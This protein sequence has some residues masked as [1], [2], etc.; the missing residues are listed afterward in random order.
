MCDMYGEKCFSP[1][2]CLQWAKL[3]KEGLNS[4]QDED[5]PGKST[6]FEHTWNDGFS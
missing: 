1:K 6:M 2:K 5:R 3:F 4:I